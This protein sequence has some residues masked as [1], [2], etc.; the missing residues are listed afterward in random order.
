MEL[1]VG[2]AQQLS[3]RLKF[4]FPVVK[5]PLNAGVDQNLE[6][7]NAWGMR[8]VD[9]GVADTDAIFSCLGNRVDLGMNRPIAVLLKFA[10][11]GL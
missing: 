10:A 2:A 3:N 6:T 4:I 7:M 8:D 1:N 9:I 5:D 11:W